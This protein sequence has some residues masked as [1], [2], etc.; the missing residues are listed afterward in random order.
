M[1]LLCIAVCAATALA[2][3]DGASI[4]G[5]WL[6]DAYKSTIS[7]LQSPNTCNFWPTCSQFG[8]AAIRQNGILAGMVMTADRLTRCHPG[9]WSYYDKYYLGMSHDRL[10]DAPPGQVSGVSGP[11][12]DAR[13]A[14]SAFAPL[15]MSESLQPT[16]VN[17]WT[18]ADHLFFV[19]HDYRRSASEY[20]RQAYSS[21]SPAE[22]DYYSLMAGEALLAAGNFAESRRVFGAVWR[23]PEFAEF[24]VARAYF[25]SGDFAAARA[26]LD[27]TFYSDGRVL[28]AGWMLFR[29]HRFRE[30]AAQF[31]SEP[32][33]SGLDALATLDGA[34]IPHRSRLVSTALSAVFPGLGQVYSGRAADGLYSFLAVAGSGLATYWYAA[35]PAKRD[36]TRIKVSLAAFFT[37]LFYS[38]NLYG[39]NVAAR[40]YNRYHE[41]QYA[42][43][44][45]ELLAGR[46]LTP[47][48]RHALGIDTLD[49]N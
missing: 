41:R 36:R 7:P 16:R 39:A 40:D 31:S 13:P 11:G 49:H 10:C 18:F 17:D 4:G 43:R 14:P 33:G 5:N 48:Y 42:A 29:E 38:G 6:I 22:Y 19:L 21:S 34:G 24:G 27:K 25:N 46:P 45:E 44:A 28:L 2:G 1:R 26:A 15:V 20:L 12:S 47:D 3:Y 35:E 9:A 32:P 37:A 30:A 23:E 8:K